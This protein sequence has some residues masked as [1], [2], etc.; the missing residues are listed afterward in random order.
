MFYNSNNF[1]NKKLKPKAFENSFELLPTNRLQ[2]LK[3]F[4]VTT[5]APK[6]YIFLDFMKH[7]VIKC[8]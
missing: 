1:Y 5:Q 8:I 3:I 6:E 4:L 7:H 2:F